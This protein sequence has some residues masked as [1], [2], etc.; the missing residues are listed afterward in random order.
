[1]RVYFATNRQ[2]NRQRRPDDFLPHPPPADPLDLR[3]G[4]AE[5]SDDGERFLDFE[6]AGEGR[7]A[8][9][10]RR[11]LGS[12]AVFDSLRRAMLEQPADCLFF[13]HGFANTFKSAILRAAQL[14]LF[15]GSERGGFSKRLHPFAFCWPSEGKVLALPNAYKSDREM[16]RLSGHALARVALRAGAFLDGLPPDSLCGRRI[17]LL[18]HSMGNWALR[19]AMPYF[20]EEAGGIP[21]GLLDQAILA[22]ADVDDDALEEEAKL[23]PLARMAR[24]V[25]VYLN[26]QDSAL[27]VSRT[28]KHGVRRLGQYGPR[29]PAALDE[30]VTVVNCSRVI[31]DKGDADLTTHQYYRN[32]ESVRRDLVAVLKGAPDEA[33]PNRAWVPEKRYYSLERIVT[34]EPPGQF[35][36]PEPMGERGG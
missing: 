2:P 14:T 17:H 8:D 3:Y 32:D 9:P 29:D 28:T 16:A 1:M 19:S 26:H 25:T 36:L 30:A 31:T 7:L 12:D 27:H 6:L 20:A 21:I 13:V 5:V 18:A 11:V 35:H 4:I 34:G 33:I 15:Y 24:R 23:R 22:G 10:A